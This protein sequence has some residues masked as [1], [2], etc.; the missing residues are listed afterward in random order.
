MEK[1]DLTNIYRTF[2]PTAIELTFFSAEHRTLFG[3]DY[4][5]G[6]TTSLHTLKIIKITFSIF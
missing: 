6:Y 5:L 4:I 3:R 2:Y 1:M